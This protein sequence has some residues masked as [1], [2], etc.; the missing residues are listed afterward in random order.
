MIMALNAFG[1]PCMYAST[2]MPRT[3]LS[4]TSTWSWSGPICDVSFFS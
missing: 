3:W 1:A 4:A 2:A